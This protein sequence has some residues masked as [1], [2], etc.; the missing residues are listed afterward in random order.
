MAK[1]SS[2]R[3]IIEPG[4]NVNGSGHNLFIIDNR[5]GDQPLQVSRI[6]YSCSFTNVLGGERGAFRFYKVDSSSS[7][8]VAAISGGIP[9]TRASPFETSANDGDTRD[10]NYKRSTFL[11][12]YTPDAADSEMIE[13]GFVTYDRPGGQMAGCIVKGGDAG[14]MRYEGAH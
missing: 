2:F 5:S 14:G 9:V 6:S 11:F 3:V 7:N 12:R 13:I 8:W 4:S 10:V 1:N